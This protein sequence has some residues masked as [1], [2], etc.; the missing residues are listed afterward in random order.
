MFQDQESEQ[1]KACYAHLKSQRYFQEINPDPRVFD[2]AARLRRST[3]P[4]LSTPDAIHLA[5]AI[6]Y[7]ATELWCLDGD[8]S[9]VPSAEYKGIVIAR[10]YSQ[11]AVIP[12]VAAAAAE[13]KTTPKKRK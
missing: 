1:A 8:F 9:A 5:T 4:T 12:V 6:H 11:Q 10:P 13:A 2:I 7:D 3:S